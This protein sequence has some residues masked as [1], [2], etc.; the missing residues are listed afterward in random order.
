MFAITVTYVIQPGHEEDAADHFRQC[1][2]HSR[3][4]PGNQRYHAYRSTDE[5][6]KFFLFEE[7]DDEAAFQAHRATPHFA[8]HITEGI[9]TIME[10]RSAHRIEPLDI[11]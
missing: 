2:R 9:M 8:A 4:E 5:P 7:Y 1:L 3:Q 10:T 11:T 6:R